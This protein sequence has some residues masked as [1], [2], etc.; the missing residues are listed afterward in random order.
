MNSP[1]TSTDAPIEGKKTQDAD[2][3]HFLHPTYFMDFDNPE[4]RAFAE[5][6]TAG[7]K[8]DVEKAVALFYAVRDEIRYNPYELKVEPYAYRASYTLKAGVGW[9]V[10]KGILMAAAARA[11]G[12]PARPG[13]T[14]VLNHLATKRFQKM[15]GTGVFS[16]HGY[17]ELWLGGPWLKVTPVFNIELCEKF[18]V[19]PQDF[20]GTGDSLFQ[21]F[22]GAG[23]KHMEYIKDHGVYDDLPL[24]EIMTDFDRR[25]GDYMEAVRKGLVGDFM[26]E[27]AAEGKSA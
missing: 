26:A 21:E 15:M 18:G 11:V 22:D 20:D 2:P 8:S 19:L 1:V 13:Y 7:A 16:Y 9:C 10:P 12:I 6:R 23:R 14:D 27:A 24:N 17:V 25:Y 4:V 5:S 3:A